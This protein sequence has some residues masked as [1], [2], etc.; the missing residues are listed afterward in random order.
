MA[1]EEPVAKID[2]QIDLVVFRDFE[3]RLFVLHVHR[4]QLV[5]D[6]WRVLC[7]VDEAELLVGDLLLQV[8]PRLELD[9]FALNLLPPAVLVQALAEENHVRQHDTIVGEVDAVAHPVEI[10]GEDLIDEH[11]LSVLIVKQVIVAL[12]SGLVGGRR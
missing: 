8:R 3:N 4:H 1:L 9:A 7:V 5:A 10:Q 12:P 6:L 11:L 2:R